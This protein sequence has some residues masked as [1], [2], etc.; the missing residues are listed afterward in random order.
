MTTKL[1]RLKTTKSAGPDGFHPRVLNELALS[2]KLL[3]S[4]IFAKSYE[5]G[6]LPMAWKE[7]QITPIHKNG[8]KAVTGN[9]RPVSLTS[10]VGK[11]MESIIRDRLVKHMMDHSLICDAQHGFVPGRSCMTQL[12]TTMEL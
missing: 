7:A 10:V 5:T 12:F 1:K 11:I 8:K 6:S 3:L 9:Y 4:I 2:I